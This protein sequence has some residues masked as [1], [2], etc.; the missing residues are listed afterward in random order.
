LALALGLSLAGAD[1]PPGHE[2][3]LRWLARAESLGL[4]SVW[5]PEGHF[6]P[7]ASASPLLVL[8]AFAARTRRVRLGTTSLLISIH[9]PLRVA[10]EVSAL[11]ALSHGRVWLGLGRGFR[12]P[13]FRGFGVAPDR[14]RD[15][16]DEAIDAILAAWSGEPLSLTGDFFETKGRAVRA[17][18]RPL[19]RPHPPLLVAAFGRKGLAQAAARGLPY[20]AS[21]LEPLA[22]LVENHAF[23]RAHLARPL[24]EDVARA[25]VMRTVHVAR[26]DR[27]AARV[28]AALEAEARRLPAGRLPAALARA[29]EG[30]VSER[31]LV[32]TREAVADGIARYRERLEMDLLIAR[33]Q[34]PGADEAA[35]E[36][37]LEALAEIC[38]GDVG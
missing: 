34:V 7:G 37:S 13:L 26:D 4:H 27:E 21:P 22:L 29:A 5:L 8:A 20:L 31:V 9:H 38:D 2:R 11:D 23:H 1:D 3:R 12:E 32:G 19:Q 25:P 15:R 28:H 16:F 14:K 36:A 35:Q 17:A 6:A 18:L 24:R 10:D 33:G 30:D